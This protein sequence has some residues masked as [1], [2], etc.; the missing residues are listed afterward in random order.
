MPCDLILCHIATILMQMTHAV[1]DS[2]YCGIAHW[3]ETSI[4]LGRGSSRFKSSNAWDLIRHWLLSQKEFE[5]QGKI[6]QAYVGV[7]TDY[8]EVRR[9]FRSPFFRRRK[10]WTFKVPQVEG[11]TGRKVNNFALAHKR[12]EVKVRKESMV[13]CHWKG[14]KFIQCHSML[15]RWRWRRWYWKPREPKQISRFRMNPLEFSLNL[16]CRKKHL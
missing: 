8:L 4:T 11:P 5:S 13:G 1:S 14:Q 2:L 9:F 12:T 16:Q 10:F 6:S 7:N 3:Y 15:I